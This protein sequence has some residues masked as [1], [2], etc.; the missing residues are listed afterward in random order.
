MDQ[1]SIDYADGFPIAL[2]LEALA[3]AIVAIVSA[4]SLSSGWWAWLGLLG[5]SLAAAVPTLYLVDYLQVREREADVVGFISE[6]DLYTE[7][8]WTRAVGLALVAAA[9]ALRAVPRSR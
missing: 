5:G 9:F 2:L 7:F 1:F 6:H 3:L 4:V 8:L